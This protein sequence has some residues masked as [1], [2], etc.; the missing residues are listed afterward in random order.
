MKNPAIR[1]AVITHLKENISDVLTWFDGRPGNIDVSE[2]PAIAVYVT[3][4]RKTA[5]YLDEASWSAVLHV[6]IFLK[7]KATDTELDKFIET[8][9]IPFMDS[10]PALDELLESRDVIGYDYQRDDEMMYWGSA[11]YQ[12]SISYLTDK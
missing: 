9:V 11:D 3:D 10:I 6:E 8:E 1:A 12:V 7:A 2:L 4:T 5:D